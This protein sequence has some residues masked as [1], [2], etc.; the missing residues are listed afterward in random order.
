MQWQYTP[1]LIP[2]LISAA[3][4]GILAILVWRRRPMPGATAYAVL[5]FFVTVWSLGYALEL[6]RVDMS[7]A[8]FGTKIEYIGITGAPLAWL[9][10]ALDY[11]GERKRLA[12]RTL[13]LLGIIPFITLV[14]AWTNEFH[15]L[16]W[17]NTTQITSGSFYM[18]DFEY[19]VWLWTYTAYTYLMLLAGA[20]QFVLMLFH[21]PR[22]YRGQAIV[23]LLGAWAHCRTWN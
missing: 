20:W 3:L 22:L 21:A 5:M 19:G 6:S 7:A 10:A 9:A 14:L 16:I 17:S 13:L 12:P 4:T 15:H 11:G 1:Y 2:L 8:I 18:L 23:V